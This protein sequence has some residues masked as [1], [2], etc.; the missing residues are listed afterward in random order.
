MK[1]IN[2]PIAL[3]NIALMAKKSYGHLVKA[4]VDVE[5]KI[6]ALDADLHADEEK[7]LIER[8][9]KQG[10]L[11]GINLYPDKYPKEE[12]LEFDSVINLRPSQKNLS[13]GVDDKDTRRKIKQVVG[14]LITP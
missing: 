2:R 13:R 11:W 10:N 7:E 14:S 1:L 9:S 8:G 5:K 4:V 6:I 3:K 12:F